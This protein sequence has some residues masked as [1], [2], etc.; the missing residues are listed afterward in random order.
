VGIFD[1]DH[2]SM[3]FASDDPALGQ[4]TD[5]TSINAIVTNPRV[6]PSHRKL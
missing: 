5:E 1:G 2:A 6:M 4:A 3:T